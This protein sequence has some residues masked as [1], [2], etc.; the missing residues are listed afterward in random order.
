M[1]SNNTSC[2]RPK[3][4]LAPVPEVTETRRTPGSGASKKA[5]SAPEG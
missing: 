1:R 3:P 4:V 2:A 5:S